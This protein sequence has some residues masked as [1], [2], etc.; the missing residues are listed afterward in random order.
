MLARIGI[1]SSVASLGLEYN[2]RCVDKHATS[3]TYYVWKL[4]IGQCPCARYICVCIYFYEDCVCVG[5]YC[6]HMYAHTG[7]LCE[8]FSQE[9]D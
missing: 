7:Y 3:V 1:V 4:T 6:D 5:L 9:R 2:H 8:E